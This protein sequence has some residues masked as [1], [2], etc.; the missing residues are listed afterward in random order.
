VF[1]ELIVSQRVQKFPVNL[2]AH[3]LRGLVSENG[4]DHDSCAVRGTW[5]LP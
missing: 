3:A 5:R 4:L 2:P 1:V